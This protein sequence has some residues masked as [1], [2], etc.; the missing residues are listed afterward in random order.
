MRLN[1]LIF[2]KIHERMKHGS[3]KYGEQISIDDKRVFV[4]EALEEALDMT[5]YLAASILQ[6][7]Y[8]HSQNLQ[9]TE[10]EDA[11]ESAIKAF[12][13]DH[14]QTNLASQSAQLQ[15][16]VCIVGSLRQKLKEK[17]HGKE[18]SQ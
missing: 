1:E 18:K 9:T 2:E 7:E 6:V 16:R 12:T 17:Y 10:I 11:V 8:K 3:K 4:A 14:P 13:D 15:L 5:I